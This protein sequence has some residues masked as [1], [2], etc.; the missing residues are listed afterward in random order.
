MKLPACD[1]ND[2]ERMHNK[3]IRK[4]A[5]PLHFNLINFIMNRVP[6]DLYRMRN[7]KM[8]IEKEKNSKNP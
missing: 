7:P 3:K 6:S 5:L 2:E 1:R 8:R 4:K